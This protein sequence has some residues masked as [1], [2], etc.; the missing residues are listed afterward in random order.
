MNIFHRVYELVTIATK[1]NST[2]TI[3][4]INSDTGAQSDHIVTA[5]SE[6]DAINIAIAKAEEENTK[7]PSPNINENSLGVIQG[8]TFYKPKG[9]L[10]TLTSPFA[11]WRDPVYKKSILN[12]ARSSTLKP[13]SYLL[14]A[15]NSLKPQKLT[16][17]NI[18]PSRKNIQK[19]INLNILAV[20]GWAAIGCISFL[21][22]LHLLNR[23]PNYALVTQLPYIVCTVIG[24][25][26]SCLGLFICFRNFATL[27]NV[28]DQTNAI[29]KETIN[30]KT[31]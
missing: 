5:A 14:S 15:T 25:I 21:S 22:A 28:D 30:D 31:T 23:I 16:N 4:L 11:V 8:K 18:T 12:S 20:F 29:S 1:R 27:N 9:V 13:G 24:T 3:T 7:S 10:R 26:A 17:K 19:A 2:Y 6:D